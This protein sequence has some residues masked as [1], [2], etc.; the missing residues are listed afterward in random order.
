MNLVSSS[1]RCL[2]HMQEVNVAPSEMIAIN[3]IGDKMDLPCR[4]RHRRKLTSIRSN[5]PEEIHFR[6]ELASRNNECRITSTHDENPNDPGWTRDFVL[7]ALAFF[8]LF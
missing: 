1:Q 2:G 6:R 3:A 4:R 7:R 8:S 5:R